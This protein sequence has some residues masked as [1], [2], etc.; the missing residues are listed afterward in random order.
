MASCASVSGIV[1]QDGCPFRDLLRIRA[2]RLTR[3]TCDHVRSAPLARVP[4]AT[5]NRNRRL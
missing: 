3:S 4:V 1:Y 2:K 5:M